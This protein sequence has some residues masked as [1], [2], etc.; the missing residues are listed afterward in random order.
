M[1]NMLKQLFL[2]TFF[3]GKVNTI[4]ESCNPVVA[5]GKHLCGSATGN[6]IMINFKLFESTPVVKYKYIV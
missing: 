5:V 4:S 2:L 1:I 6:L 3:L